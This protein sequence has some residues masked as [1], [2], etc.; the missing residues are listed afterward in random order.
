MS[1][2]PP[3][4]P[5]PPGAS[6]SPP[7]QPQPQPA[8]PPTPQ[9]GAPPTPQGAYYAPPRTDGTA[10]AALIL[11]IV[12]WVVCPIIAAIVALALA[13]SAGNKID[14]SAGRV[15]GGGLV[16]AAQIIAWLNIGL[17]TFGMFVAAVALVAADGF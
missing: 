5:P 11:S 16:R 8:A 17:I 2:V 15:T 12:S 4:P 6:S 14:A 7:P 10:I 3:P 9:W 1:Q 13:H